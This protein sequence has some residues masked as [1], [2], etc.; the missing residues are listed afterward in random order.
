MGE[1]TTTRKQVELEPDVHQE[2]ML[3]KVQQGH[4]NM[5]EAVKAL[6]DLA[7]LKARQEGMLNDLV[8]DEVQ[9]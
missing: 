5:N 2:L 3:F 9:S 8:D 1:E 7:R 4:K 6:L